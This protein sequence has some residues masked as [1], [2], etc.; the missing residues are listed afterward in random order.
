MRDRNDDAKLLAACDCAMHWVL[1][2]WLQH[3]CT[4]VC[5]CVRSVRVF[6]CACVRMCV[7]KLRCVAGGVA[8]GVAGVV[9]RL[10]FV[11]E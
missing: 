4:C 1:G 2:Q 3:Q 7:R 9:R 8:G 10:R 11:T 5:A 6:V